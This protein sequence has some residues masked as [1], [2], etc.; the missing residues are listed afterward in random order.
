MS[1]SKT[2]TVHPPD[3]EGGRLVCV[4]EVAAGRAYGLWD[5]VVFLHR[6]GLDRDF[7]DEDEIAA[8]ELIEWL[9]GGPHVWE[10][11]ADPS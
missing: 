6:A 3:V 9:G 5:V 2:V 11:C 4:R 8:S 7:G 10:Q 1:A